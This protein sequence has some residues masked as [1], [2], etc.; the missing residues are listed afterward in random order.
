MSKLGYF[1]NYFTLIV[2][3]FKDK[4]CRMFAFYSVFKC[5]N[6]DDHA[7]MKKQY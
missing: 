1:K 7:E 3:E 6:S 2:K 4:H 5:Q